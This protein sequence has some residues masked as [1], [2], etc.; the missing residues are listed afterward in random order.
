DFRGQIW[1]RAAILLKEFGPLLSGLGTSCSHSRREVL[2]NAVGHQK[3][4]VFGPA[5]GAFGAP[6]LLLAERFAVRR[7]RVLLARRTVPD[8]AVEDDERGAPLG[9]PKDR[10]GALDAV[11][12][13]GIANAD[14]IPPVAQEARGDVLG[15]GNAG[16]TLDG[17]VV[18]VVDPAE[19]IETQVPRQ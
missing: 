12:V 2:V 8:V 13:V 17:D 11:D 10:E 14:H 15:E 1:I 5:V 3:L 7:R 6:A 4:R 16:V 18:V 19:V 9:W